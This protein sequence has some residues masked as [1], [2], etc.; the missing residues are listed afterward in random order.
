ME[1]TLKKCPMC[2]EDI[3]LSTVT[4]EYCGAQFEVTRT[5]YCQN[6]HQVREADGKCQCKVCGN[7]VMDLRIESRLIEDP[8]LAV[9]PI[10]KPKITKT[11]KSCLP[12]GILTAFLFLAVIGVSLWLGRD[13]IAGI[14]SEFAAQTPTTTPTVPPTITPSATPRPTSTKRPTSTVTPAPV[15]VTFDTISSYL[16]DRLVI[17]SGQLVL[18]SGTK[19]DTDCGLLLAEYTNSS[20]SITIFVEVAEPGV[21]PVPN[22]MKALPNPYQK[23]DIRVRLNDGT[24]AFI[25]QRVTV[26][27]RICSTTDGDTCISDIFNIELAK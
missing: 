9:S 19:C 23:W 8:V 17:M 5:G 24:Y 25:G 27:G 1:A 11:R 12:I 3:Q 10:A 13:N 16:E 26:T 18:F 7:R 22:Q 14:S 2:A 21:E 4:C 15:E 20:K 6:C